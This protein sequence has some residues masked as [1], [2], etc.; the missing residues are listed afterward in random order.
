MKKT[1]MITATLFL[2]LISILLI[3]LSQKTEN[4]SF[5][6]INASQAKEMIDQNPNVIILDVRT[7]EEY[8]EG[9]IENATLLPYDTIA[10]Q[11][12]VTLPDTSSTILVYCRSGRRSS[13]AA[14]SLVDL[15]YS[16]I[17]DFGGIIDWPYSIIT[18]E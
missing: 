11:A 12:K 17:Y 15:G 8:L 5:Q 18:G 14:Q 6:T 2:A 7:N 1:I 3:T 13:I 10:Q 16:N 9:H 4:Q